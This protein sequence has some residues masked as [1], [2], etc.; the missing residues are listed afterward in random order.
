VMRHLL[1]HPCSALLGTL[2]ARP[3]SSPRVGPCGCL[4]DVLTRNGDGG[5]LDPPACSP[6]SPQPAQHHRQ[7]FSVLVAPQGDVDGSAGDFE[8]LSAQNLTDTPSALSPRTSL[9]RQNRP[10]DDA[11]PVQSILTVSATSPD[12]SIRAR[13]G[14]APADGDL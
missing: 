9:I 3:A 14:R 11:P 5:Q 2:R 10:R 13:K 1:I 6:P 12:R 7:T 4:R 8:C